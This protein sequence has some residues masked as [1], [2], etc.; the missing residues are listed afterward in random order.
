MSVSNE[1]SIIT[2]TF[3]CCKGMTPSHFRVSS[4]FEVDVDRKD[5]PFGKMA[6][7]NLV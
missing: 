7:N 1:M 6:I 2:L 3:V 5:Y 4:G